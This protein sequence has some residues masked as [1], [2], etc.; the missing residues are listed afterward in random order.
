[1]TSGTNGFHPEEVHRHLGAQVDALH[2]RDVERAIAPLIGRMVAQCYALLRQELERKVKQD[3]HLYSE[4][5]VSGIMQEFDAVA[6]DIQEA[7]LE[8]V[9]AR[10]LALI[11]EEVRHVFEDALSNAEETLLDAAPEDDGARPPPP[12]PAARGRPSRARPPWQVEEGPRPV[13]P[14]AAEGP[15]EQAP[16]AA[17]PTPPADAAG[18]A[19]EA[20][21]QAAPPREAAPA[22]EALTAAPGGQEGE[23]VFVPSDAEGLPDEVAH[24][25]EEEVYEGTVRLSVEANGS[26]RQ[27]I[28]F[29]DQLREKPQFRLLQ[30][31]GN[32]K[33]GLHI[34]LGLREALCLKKVLLQME[35]VAQVGVPLG[36][37]PKGHERLLKVRLAEG[38]ASS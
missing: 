9:K 36:R 17:T 10:L 32:H 15:E 35:G 4:A 34:W 27:L 38:L 29:V 18:G 12:A 14:P 6:E 19:T 28:R 30:L 25:P 5:R 8:R 33:E 7:T 31:V 11:Q 22:T 20:A 26:V 24:A 3:P 37:S 16:R 2:E 13:V 21:A 1:M 23:V